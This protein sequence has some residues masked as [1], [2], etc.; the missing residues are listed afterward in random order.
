MIFSGWG[1]SEALARKKATAISYSPS[2]SRSSSC[3]AEALLPEMGA[4]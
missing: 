4:A 3:T 1:S 2:S